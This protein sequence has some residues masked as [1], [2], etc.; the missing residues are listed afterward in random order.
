MKR[1]RAGIRLATTDKTSRT[2]L[3]HPTSL[4]RFNDALLS[5]LIL[6][7]KFNVY[8][9]STSHRDPNRLGNILYI[10][11]RHELFAHETK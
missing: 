9:I 5:H 3:I 11:M 6:K 2:N 7:K 8:E 4:I 10:I 1:R